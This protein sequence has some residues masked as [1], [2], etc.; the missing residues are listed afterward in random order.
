MNRCGSILLVLALFG[1]PLWAGKTESSGKA[2]LEKIRN[3]RKAHEQEII[4]EFCQ[5]L[6]I[7]NVALD[8]ENI[9]KNAVFIKTMLEKRGVQ[10]QV[11]PT[12]GNPVV[13]GELKV[14]N[15]TETMLFYIH[16]DGQP[17]D[18]SQ[19]TDSLPYAPVLRPGKLAAGATTPQPIPF[20]GKNEHFEDNWRLYAR[21]TSDDKAPLIAL[22]TAIDALK[23]TGFPLKK[24][25]KFIL[26][27]EEEAGSPSLPFFLNQYKDLLTCDV[28]L[29]CDGPTYY[30]GDPTLVYGVRGVISFSITVYG[31]DTS[32][33][34][35]HY[36]NWAPNPALHLAQ[37]LASMKDKNGKITIN[38][39]YDT[40]VPL[41]E[42]EKEALKA[43][44][45]Y[46]DVLEKQY[47]FSEAES[48]DMPLMEAILYPSLN[49]NG[50]QSGYVGKQSSTII[51]ATA[52]AS[53]DIRLVKGN[54]PTDMIQKVK[55]HI[56][57]QGYYVTETEPDRET[58]L[59]YPLI[60]KFRLEDKGYRA[61]RT[62]MD[63]PISKNIISALNRF[64]HKR[65]VLIPTLGGSLPVYIFEDTLHVPVIGVPI[66]NYDNNQHQQNENIRIGH[67][68]QAIET[69]SALLF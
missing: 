19:W 23:A 61:S 13:F 34:S 9:L 18:P 6:A 33:H 55:D 52:Y 38:G 10:T 40:M 17:V 12:P 11:L 36:G 32:L 30:S 66:A 29:M 62:S 43:L 60:A 37:L 8:K 1:T 41:S 31:P 22:L 26:D 68:W 69:F 48:G 2:G 58:R 21:S 15:A 64:S 16:Y 20:P 54:D 24:N 39:F 51:P 3:Y 14:K 65:V 45:R 25:I 63:L 59:K 47:A 50:L 56:I 28:L 5:L 35:G 67:L 57:S 27:G 49:I 46:D 4:K 44:P 42:R 7:P 53:L